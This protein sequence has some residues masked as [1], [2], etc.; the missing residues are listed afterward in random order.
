MVV[1]VRVVVLEGVSLWGCVMLTTEEVEKFCTQSKSVVLDK[2]K[3]CS[4]LQKFGCFVCVLPCLCVCVC[5]CVCLCNQYCSSSFTSDYLAP[6]ARFVTKV[7]LGKYLL[8]LNLSHK[9]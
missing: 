7:I 4:I 8:Y 5:L 9:T 1:V 3:V 2:V 6:D